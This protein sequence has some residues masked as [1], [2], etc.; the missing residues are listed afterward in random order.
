MSSEAPSSLVKPVTADVR[1]C[2]L[3]ARARLLPRPARPGG[4]PCR[5][6]ARAARCSCCRSSCSEEQSPRVSSGAKEE[7]RG[8]A[9]TTCV[10]SCATNA[11]SSAEVVC[12]VAAGAG[13]SSVIGAAVRRTAA[14]RRGGPL[15]VQ[16]RRHDARRTTRS[17]ASFSWLTN[18]H[19]LPR[20]RWALR[21]PEPAA[22]R[23]YNLYARYI[24]LSRLPL[25]DPGPR[26]ERVGYRLDTWCLA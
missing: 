2:A 17:S 21:A 1:P 7:Q 14:L 15:L 25:R 3:E 22:M 26:L 18:S 20:G 12:V 10:R 6:A 19:W 4:R 8:C 11:A 9:L 13:L 5:L 16:R 24:Y 23:Y